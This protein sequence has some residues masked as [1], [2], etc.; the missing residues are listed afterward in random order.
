MGQPEGRQYFP[1][2]G[3]ADGIEKAFPIV[4]RL[5]NS[6]RSGFV[7][8]NEINAKNAASAAFFATRK[9]ERKNEKD[10]R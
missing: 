9:E 2:C 1:E 5:K 7:R 6:N 3:A 10:G 8:Q 4:G